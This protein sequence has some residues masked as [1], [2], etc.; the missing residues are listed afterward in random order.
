MEKIKQLIEDL[1]TWAAPNVRYLLG[2]MG[3]E[4]SLTSVI[5]S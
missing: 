3:L 1:E 5:L 4:A 2:C